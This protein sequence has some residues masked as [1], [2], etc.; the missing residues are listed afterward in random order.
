MRRD[1]KSKTGQLLSTSDLTVAAPIRPGLVPAL[2]A[3]SYKTRVERLLPLLQ[4]G[5]LGQHEF[6]FTRVLADAVERVGLIHA[7]RVAVI[8]PQNLVMLSV[9][10]DGAWE[11]YMRVVWQKVARLLDLIFCNTVGYVYGWESS[12][13]EWMVW[14]RRHQ[15]STPF[16][17]AQPHGTVGDGEL[18]RGQEWVQ[19][20]GAD[21]ELA[22][23]KMGVLNADLVEATLSNGDSSDP[24]FPGSRGYGTPVGGNALI[25]RQSVRALAALHRLTD[26]YL[27][28]TNDG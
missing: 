19:R 9:T 11:P 26:M 6:E 14:L 3:V 1:I 8:E 4:L 25:A 13:D 23:R 12:F 18:R 22:A 28:G 27:P 17:Y 16:L 7:V 10:F 20:Q 2:D 5:R 21:R 15:V 24:R